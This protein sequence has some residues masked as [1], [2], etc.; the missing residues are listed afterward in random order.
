[1][2]KE[3]SLGHSKWDVPEIQIHMGEMG[4]LE[5]VHIGTKSLSAYLLSGLSGRKWDNLPVPWQ[6]K[7]SPWG[8]GWGNLCHSTWGMNQWW[9][10]L[11]LGQSNDDYKHL[12]LRLKRI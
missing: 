6:C 4:A 8:Q 3:S 1:M 5:H 9:T 7:Y 12:I 11:D 2:G 10:S